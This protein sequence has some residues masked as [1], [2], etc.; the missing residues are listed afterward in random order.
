MP[1]AGTV[2]WHIFVVLV[3]AKL[4]AEIAERIG[5]P[6]V[7][8]EILAGIA[9]GPSVLG[10]VATDEILRALGE[11]GVVLL[12]LQVGLEM[13]LAEF[14]RVG[15]ASILVAVIG[16]AL[17]FAGGYAVALAFGEQNG[18]AI[19][20][21]AAL[22]ATSVGIT[23]RV[24]SDL[25][26][27]ARVEARTVLGAA[28]ADD[29][30]GLVI[31]TLV[32]KTVT[33]GSIS[34]IEIARALILATLFLV[35]ATVVGRRV[36]PVL[37]T[38]VR[39]VARSSGTFTAFSLAFPLGF[40]VLAGLAGLAPIVGA[41]IAGLSLAGSPTSDRVRRDLAPLGHLLIPIFF[42]QIGIDAQ[43]SV[44]AQADV[45]W[46]GGA[47]LLVAIVGKLLAAVGAFGSPGDKLL[48]GI[49]MLPRGEVG[50][51]FAGIGLST[52]V[53]DPKLY[54]ALLLVVIVST[55][56][57]PP[58]LRRRLVRA[59][60]LATAGAS[61]LPAD[62]RWLRVKDGTVELVAEPPA[63]SKDLQIAMEAALAASEAKPGPHLLDWI[64]SLDGSRLT[65]DP[66]SKEAFFALL[67]SADPRSWRFL[68][69]SNVLDRALPELAEVMERRGRDMAELDPT[70]G[71]R[72]EVVDAIHELVRTDDLAGRAFANLR[73]PEWLLFAALILDVVEDD[74]GAV[75][76]ARKL[77]GRL[78]LGAA[79]EQEVALLVGDSSLLRA[80]AARDDATSE[81][82]ILK[83]SG[84][85]AD[86][87]RAGALYVLSL[88]LGDL[89]ERR[90]ARLDEMYLLLGSTLRD[91]EV[92]GREA[93]N[94]LARRRSQAG[95][96][97]GLKPSA[98]TRIETAP[99]AYV[100]SVSVDELARH[101]QLMDPML[102]KGRVRSQVTPLGLGRWT[103]DLAARDTRGL[104]AWTTQ[105]LATAGLDLE[106][107]VAVTWDDGGVIQSFSVG[108]AEVP[109]DLDEMVE[110]L[111]G[112]EVTAEP[113]PEVSLSFDNDASPWYTL[114][115]V[116][117]TDRRGLLRDL[118]AA[119]T[120]AGATIHSAH[121]T[122]AS[123]RALD[124]FEL[125][126]PDGSKLDSGTEARI[127]R[128]VKEGV[129]PHV[130]RR[131][132]PR[133]LRA[134]RTV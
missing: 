93:R 5:A 113:M 15:R 82:N 60:R 50:L 129:V 75:A 98:V 62:G 20:V 87:E 115:D 120:A 63:R 27:L 65:F 12:L 1:D 109:A 41:F 24:F 84:H 69:M 11:L 73:Q 45:L 17:P 67:R 58:A 18:T 3:V 124:R 4:A 61:P 42:L 112:S 110:S 78:D 90:R 80:A 10:L 13:E 114:C 118:A 130:S 19:F 94:L 97:P 96:H 38:N 6:V 117:A 125:A 46:I 107:C 121:V 79:A 7:V 43:L 44:F 83:L 48:I 85:L 66:A 81:A 36:A 106:G 122:T 89:D 32:V 53:L 9:I 37:F 133:A 95:R 34:P 70:H 57:T 30:L 52:G 55:L 59:K 16:V 116:Q 104:L 35:V 88:A 101:A 74:P 49:G 99:D 128:N 26:A 108:G 40:A 100:L 33:A 31:L 131:R 119:V 51:I 14:L 22:T 8:A 77:V 68:E 47:L 76:M 103:I 28:V 21:G 56:V 39:R 64:A 127:L 91:P 92:S 126:M 111:L 123:H 2:L 23:A 86:G 54:A 102:A 72:W 25:R 134:R 71:L 105:A 132:F 29:V